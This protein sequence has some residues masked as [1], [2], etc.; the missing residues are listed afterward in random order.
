MTELLTMEK[1]VPGGTCPVMAAKI[2]PQIMKELDV[3]VKESKQLK[4][5]PLGTLKAH[6]NV[7][8]LASDGKAHNSY[9]CSISPYLIEKS[10]W[11][12]WVLRLSQKYWGGGKPHRCFKIR[13]WSGHFDGYDIWTNFAY[14]G[15]DNP[16]H[17]HAGFLSGVIYY[18]NHKHPTIFD[19]YN[20]AYEGKDGTMVMFPANTWHHVDPQTVNK[21]RITLAFN[22][23]QLEENVGDEL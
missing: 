21:E 15:D 12:A 8:Y 17:F 20:C 13:S 19:E 14:K 4:N 1:L 11:L 10:F 18:K 6:E 16:R 2:P 23:M 9:Q 7:G 22:V 5:S 3:W